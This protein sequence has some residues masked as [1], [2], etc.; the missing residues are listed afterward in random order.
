MAPETAFQL[1]VMLLDDT[2]VAVTPVGVAG[3]DSLVF[4]ETDEDW[5]LSPALLAADIL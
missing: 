1:T 2:T 5:V 4:A 3:I